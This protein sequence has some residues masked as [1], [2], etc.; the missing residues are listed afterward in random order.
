M[1]IVPYSTAP[2]TAR[3]QLIAAIVKAFT[4][5]PRA[6]ARGRQ[7]SSGRK[8]STSANLTPTSILVSPLNR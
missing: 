3:Q 5:F 6:R 7:H 2:L 8:P 1:N 4:A